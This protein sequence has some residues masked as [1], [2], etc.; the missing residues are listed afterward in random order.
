[1]T[2]WRTGCGSVRCGDLGRWFDLSVGG[3]FQQ[4]QRPFVTESKATRLRATTSIDDELI[5][6]PRLVAAVGSVADNHVA[7]A[8][9][10]RQID[11]G[12]A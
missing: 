8:R 3:F 11:D 1:M 7:A 6:H 4:R 10:D 5:D 9:F 12:L 2:R